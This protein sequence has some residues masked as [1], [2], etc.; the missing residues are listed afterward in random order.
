MPEAAR[1]L[2]TR[3]PHKRAFITGA[4]SGL[5]LALATNLARDGWTIGRL[6]RDAARLADTHAALVAAGAKLHDYT[7]DVTDEASFAA[8]VEG[9]AAAAGGIDV[10]INNA[11]V[12]VSGLI[13]AT[14]AA[15]WRWILD[16]NVTA[17]A[18]GCRLA[19]PHLRAAPDGGAVINIAS[20]AG[21]VAPPR[22]GAYNAS[23]AAVIA[24]TES[25]AAELGGTRITATAVMPTFFPTRL[26]DDARMPAR[27]AKTARRWMDR[28]KYSAEACAEDLLAAAARGQV[29]APLPADSRWLWRLKRAMPTFI[30]RRLRKAAT[31]RKPS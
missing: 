25:L 30:L 26:L 23:K 14:P 18:T 16:I 20:A 3:L 15:D 17:V 22:M 12:V 19:M 29:H 27:E 10:M 4:G 8:A 1:R 5:G 9:F 24:L 31:P 7:G 2:G 21:F 6:E 28:S 13:E 11:G